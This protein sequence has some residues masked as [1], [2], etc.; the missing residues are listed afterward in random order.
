MLADW[1]F[2]GKRC[3]VFDSKERTR[4]IFS[5]IGHLMGKKSPV[6]QISTGRVFFLLV[7][8]DRYPVEGPCWLLES[9]SRLGTLVSSIDW[10]FLDEE[11]RFFDEG[12][13]TAFRWSLV[14][15]A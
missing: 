8:Q 2:L 5:R 13:F 14:G 3:F 9:G 1:R 12:G 4:R 7:D 15:K 11:H 10:T 6:P